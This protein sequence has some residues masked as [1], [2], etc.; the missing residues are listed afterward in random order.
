MNWA[1]EYLQAEMDYRIERAQGD[2]RTTLEHRRAAAKSHQSWWH[3][4][5]AHPATHHDESE[6]SRAA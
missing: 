1:P 6:E 5:V 4:H 2:P 3:R